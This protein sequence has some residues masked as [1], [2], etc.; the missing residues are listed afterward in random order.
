MLH[1]IWQA[2]G[3][4][5]GVTTTSGTWIGDAMVGRE[6]LSG[7]PGAKL[8]L[9]DPSVEAAV[10]EMPRKGLAIF[11]QA[12]DRYD[13]AA[14]TNV[15]DDHL[16]TLGVQTLDQM[17][18]LKSRVLEQAT[19]AIVVN[20]DDERCLA[21]RHRSRCKRHILVSRNE[22]NAALK[23][24]LSQGGEAVFLIQSERINWICLAK[25]DS[26]LRLMTTESIPAT[27]EGLLQFNETNAMFA[28]ALAWAQ[29]IEL[30]MIV[31]ALKSFENNE[32][33]NP[34]RYNFVEGLP[35]K[36]MLDYA[37]NPSGAIEVARIASSMKVD[38]RKRLMCMNIGNRHKHHI[39]QSV[40]ALASS[41]DSIIISG[42]KE[43]VMASADWHA[44][45][46]K[47][48]AYSNM[49]AYFESNILRVG[50]DKNELQ[51]EPDPSLACLRILK[52][53]KPNDLVIILGE[54]SDVMPV[55]RAYLKE[56]DAPEIF[57]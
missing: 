38:G 28:V 47:E 27:M 18:L 55:I 49:L 29:K 5:C 23:H 42:D 13:V 21:V 1:H 43:R 17:A 22:N 57:N 9:G 56:I 12:T 35:F 7:L 50:F 34:G 11:G 19:E 48:N 41:F 40:Q 26:T 51:I 25:G 31:K 6:N 36:L 46:T 8:L 44:E 39:D 4:C 37:H 3:K 15:Q 53:S 30:D 24:H 20:A 45:G 32:V 2:T 33:Q 16:G 54:A 14:L 10:L 52:K